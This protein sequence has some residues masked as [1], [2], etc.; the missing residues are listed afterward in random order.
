MSELRLYRDADER[1][2]GLPG[3]V[4]VLLDHAQGIERRI[5]VPSSARDVRTFSHA[6]QG[7][8]ARGPYSQA[9]MRGPGA[10]AIEFGTRRTP[11]Q[12]PVRR[13]VR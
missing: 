8:T 2:L 11:P 4:D 5:R 12:A 7:R 9:G 6:S 1:V 13:A 3:V 10:L